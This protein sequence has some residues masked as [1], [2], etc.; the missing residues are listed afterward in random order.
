MREFLADN[1]RPLA[2]ST[3]LGAVLYAA[4]DLAS[5]WVPPE[6][7]AKLMALSVAISSVLGAWLGFYVPRRSQARKAAMTAAGTAPIDPVAVLRGVSMSPSDE[8]VLDRLE[9][10]LRP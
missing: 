6:V 4:V 9:R 7:T 3:G 5:L 1:G 10:R 2:I 8:K